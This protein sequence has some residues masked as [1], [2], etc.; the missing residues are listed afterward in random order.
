MPKKHAGN[1]Y[2]QYERELLTEISGSHGVWVA[3]LFSLSETDVSVVFTPSIIRA[4]ITKIFAVNISAEMN[5]D[6]VNIITL[7]PSGKYVSSALTISNSGRRHIII[8]VLNYLLLKIIL[9][10]L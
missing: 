4:M 3:K 5:H 9:F 10:N 7:K 8:K 1:Y 6:G 2:A